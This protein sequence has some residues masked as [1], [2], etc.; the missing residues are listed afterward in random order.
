MLGVKSVKSN[1]Q[2]IKEL[3][4]TIVSSIP[5]PVVSAEIVSLSTEIE[6]V[7]SNKKNFK[8]T[9]KLAPIAPL[10]SILPFL[11]NVCSEMNARV[12]GSIP[13]QLVINGD[14]LS[15]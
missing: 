8:S 1:Q 14:L 4:E 10:S 2:L 3:Q 6:V 12:Q 9:I 15:L 5:S 7:L 11:E 13:D